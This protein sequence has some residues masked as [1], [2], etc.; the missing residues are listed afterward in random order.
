MPRHFTSLLFASLVVW[1]TIPARALY[2]DDA[3]ALTL[4]GS[5]RSTSVL[6]TYPD[7]ERFAA[8]Q[9]GGSVNRADGLSYGSFRLTAGGAPAPWF[10]YDLHLHQ[11][12]WFGE[13]PA[14]S[15][16]L[17]AGA[18]PTTR[19]RLVSGSH[20]WVS[21]NNAEARLSVDRAFVK[22]RLPSFDLTLGRQAVTFGKARFWNPLDVFLPFDARQFDREYKPGVDA[23]RVDVPVGEMSGLTM[24]AAPG[25]V[26]GSRVYARSWYGSAVLGRVYTNL[27]DFDFAAQGG[28]VYGGYQGGAGLTG[29][30]GPIEVRAEGAYL[31]SIDE[32]DEPTPVPDHLMAVVGVGRLFDCSLNLQAEYLYNGAGDDANLD[33]AL[34]RVAAGRAL[35]MSEHLVAAMIGYDLLP[36]LTGSVATIVSVSDGSGLVQPGLEYSVSDESDLLAG[37]M[38]AW[39][40]RPRVTPPAGLELRSE[41]GTYPD[42]FYVQYRVYF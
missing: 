10:S 32:P 7:A 34:S 21:D 1:H 3:G 16:G 11:D 2:E 5:F 8:A 24:V 37:A 31:F 20:A 36:L 38:I 25:R 27:A 28:K 29:A 12:A 23:V 26:D 13:L 14:A 40:R 18:G 30:L 41:F 17:A 39:G 4:D 19:Y 15:A 22:Y 33:A 6:V 9:P 42:F 35:Q